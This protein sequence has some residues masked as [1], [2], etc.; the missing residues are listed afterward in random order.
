M[1]LKSKPFKRNLWYSWNFILNYQYCKKFYFDKCTL[2]TEYVNSVNSLYYIYYTMQSFQIVLSCIIHCPCRPDYS[3][4]VSVAENF[5]HC[6]SYILIHSSL[7]WYAM[8]TSH[9]IIRTRARE[10]KII[11]SKARTLP[12]AKHIYPSWRILLCCNFHNTRLFVHFLIN[13]PQSF[14]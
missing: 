4:I 3:F 9:Y 1:F 12:C 5:N 13:I 2:L 11:T 6:V 10:F 8:C 7:F 14:E